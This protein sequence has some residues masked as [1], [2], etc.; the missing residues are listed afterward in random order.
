MAYEEAVEKARA[1]LG[2]HYPMLINGEKWASRGEE[3]VH[4]SPLNTRLTVSY[5]PL[6]NR[7]DARAA[8]DA[9]C[10]AFA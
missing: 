9:A 8:I 6:G 10:D 4:N 2:K 5:F 7:D 1:S 3:N